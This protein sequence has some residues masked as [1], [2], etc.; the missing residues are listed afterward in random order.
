MPRIRLVHAA[1]LHLDTPFEG[2]AGPAPRV[3]EALR[4]ASLQAWDDLVRFTI[5]QGAAALLLAGDLY[6]GAQRGVRAQIRVQRGLRDLSQAG[7][8]TFIVHGNHDPL[9]GWSAIRA[10]PPGVHVFGHEEVEVVPI[11]REGASVGHVHGIS[12]GRRD[13]A[14]NLAARFRRGDARGP[15]IGLLHTNAGGSPEHAAYAPCSLS[16]LQ[17]AGMDYWALGHIHKRQVLRGGD[18]WIV[19]PGDLQGRSPKASETGAKGAYLIEVDTDPVAFLPPVFQPLDRVRFATCPY[20]I[21]GHADLPSLHSGLL[22]SLETLRDQHAG[23]GVLARVV[24][25]GRGDVIADLRRPEA[26]L[27]L[28]AELRQAFRDATPLLWVESLVDHAA[29]ALD[30]AAI[31][32]RGEFSAEVLLRAEGLAADPA[33]LSAFGAA[34]DAALHTGQVGRQVSA[35]PADAEAEILREALARV[36]DRLEAAESA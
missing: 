4:E 17:A 8:Q 33:E 29:P 32:A 36:L 34:R 2:I 14:E 9:D 3:A 21:A 27:H 12:Y 16:D 25:E 13:V 11:E 15:H 19:Y 6:D 1:D 5:D 23:R 28:R 20:D 31:R 30:L 24:L 7:V 10:W 18:P 22:A 26:L 35:L